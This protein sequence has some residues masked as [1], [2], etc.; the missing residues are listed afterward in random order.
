MINQAIIPVLK[1]IKDCHQAKH[2]DGTYVLL[3]D[4]HISELTVAV[5]TLKDLGKK[6]LVHAELIKG[7]K[8]DP[9]GIEHL[10][11]V[12]FIDGVISVKSSVIQKAKKLKL[13]TIQRLFL[14]DKASYQ[15]SVELVKE[16]A[17]DYIEMLPGCVYKMITRLKND[18]GIEV[19][20]GGLI[21]TYEEVTLALNEGAKA[22]T[23][24]SPR[25]LDLIKKA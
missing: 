21:D 6:V 20:A 19:I 10:A 3:M 2:Y 8:S 22:I 1:S 12:H 25:L 16:T 11:H 18:T 13:L 15:R 23:T 9:Y 14:I 7:L 17:P 5:K 4:I 24:S